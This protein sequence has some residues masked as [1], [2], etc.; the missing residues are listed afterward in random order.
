MIKTYKFEY[1]DGLINDLQNNSFSTASTINKVLAFANPN[2]DDLFYIESILASVGW[3]DNDDVF[4]RVYSW[5]AR[6]TAVDKQFN[7][8]HDE[9]DI[10]GHITSS[11]I[12]ADGKIISDNIDLSEIPDK[13]DIIVGSVLY[14][15]WQDS[16][17]QQRMNQIIGEIQD[18][19]WFV[20]MECMFSDFDYALIDPTG[21]HQVLA[22]NDETSF[23]TKHLRTYG[24]NG[25]YQGYKLGRLLKN[26]AFSGKGLV[27]NPA[28]KRSIIFNFS[29]T[30]DIE[31]EFKVA[32]NKEKTMPDNDKTIQE[33]EAKLAAAEKT[34]KDLADKSIANQVADFEAKLAKL[35]S[36][37]EQSKSETKEVLDKLT[38]AEEIQANK[39]VELENVNKELESVKAELL[40]K[41]EEL[42]SIEKEKTL[43][44]RL[45]MF[46]DRVID[47]AKA[48]N[49]VQVG[50]D[51]TD[52]TFKILV[53]SFAKKEEMSDEDKKKREENKKKETEASKD[54][55]L[56]ELEVI[57]AALSVSNE[58]ETE[59][60]KVRASASA[61]MKSLYTKNKKEN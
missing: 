6:N 25:E 61:W 42:K 57:G 14:K 21:N 60:D 51:M 36:E 5:Q 24:G 37:L 27:D 55:V 33:L 22:R 59:T 10:I 52:E 38:V 35:S 50:Q 30:S 2:Q 47:Q 46:N 49:L 19:K 20:S 13:Y 54:E 43:A 29:D 41:S 7:F 34:A 17:L 15:H 53:D 11:K 16:G 1:K 39:L 8:M 32:A 58:D 28:N 31:T 18:G 4:D 23:L 9:H 48:Q 56:E 3:N 12:I 44:S 40:T 26:F 45:N